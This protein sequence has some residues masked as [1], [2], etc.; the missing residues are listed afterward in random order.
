MSEYFWHTWAV[1]RLICYFKVWTVSFLSEIQVSREDSELRIMVH[2]MLWNLVSY[3]KCRIIKDSGCGDGQKPSGRWSDSA[4]HGN[5]GCSLNW[6]SVFLVSDTGFHG[7]RIRCEGRERQ[8]VSREGGTEKET[9]SRVRSP[10]RCMWRE[11][12]PER[13]AG[14]TA[15][16]STYSSNASMTGRRLSAP[17]LPS[18][19]VEHEIL[20]LCV[21][22]KR[23]FLPRVIKS[24]DSCDCGDSIQKPWVWISC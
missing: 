11:T 23:P 20:F 18:H 17:S 22:R 14:K 4:S 13:R 8:D 16:E 7:K 12:D 9:Q 5:Q 10:D 21:L 15:G 1:S 2:N 3:I 6:G 24:S 19:S